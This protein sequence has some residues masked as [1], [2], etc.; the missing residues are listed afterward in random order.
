MPTLFGREVI[1]AVLVSGFFW[2][3]RDLTRDFAEVFGERKLRRR[4][5]AEPTSQNRD[6]GHPLL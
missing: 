2:V 6:V 5:G 3:R 1:D 4:V